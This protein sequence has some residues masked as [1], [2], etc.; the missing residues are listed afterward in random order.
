MVVNYQ[1]MSS[2]N[3]GRVVNLCVAH[4]HGGCPILALFARVGGDA[5]RATCVRS[6]LPVVYAVVAPALRKVREGQAT[7]GCGGICSLKAGPPALITQHKGV[8]RQSVW[9]PAFCGKQV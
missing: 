3:F 1:S 5:A 8:S 4:S 9:M 2:V 6:T 7:R